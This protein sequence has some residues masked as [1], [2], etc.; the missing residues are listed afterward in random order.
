MRCISKR[1][2]E[3]CCKELAYAVVEAV[4]ASGHP[5]D[6]LSERAVWKANVQTE[7]SV[8]RR[9][10]FFHREAFL[11]LRPCDELDQAHPDCLGGSSLLEAN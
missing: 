3:I 7:A 5:W 1:E 2:R 9:N 11:L 4:Q 8:H 10:F 6:R